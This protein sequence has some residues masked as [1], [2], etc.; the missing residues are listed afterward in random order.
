MVATEGAGGAPARTV[1]GAVSV[2]GFVGELVEMGDALEALRAE[3]AGGLGVRQ[4]E[5]YV[6]G[7]AAVVA[8]M[9]GDVADAGGTVECRLRGGAES[10]EAACLAGDGLEGV[11]EV[12]AFWCTRN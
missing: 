5:R 3:S 8:G 1:V 2:G 10:V 6:G 4:G 11:A 12:C 7:A 9:G